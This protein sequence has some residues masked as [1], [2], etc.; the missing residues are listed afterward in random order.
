MSTTVY[1]RDQKVYFVC[2]GTSVNKI[3]QSLPE[4]T[5]KKTSF[6]TSLFKK[7]NDNNTEEIKEEK[8][9]I[10]DKIG[11]KE[12][13]I[14]QENEKNKE[15][16]DKVDTVYTSLD[17]NAI[18]TSLLL[19]DSSKNMTVVPLPYISKETNIKDNKKFNEFK[20]EFGKYSK[21]MNY[22]STNSTNYWKVK[23]IENDFI[24]KKKIAT[25]IDWNK[26]NT[27]DSSSL[28]SFNF[29][30]FKS[31]FQ[32]LILNKYISTSIYDPIDDLI[33]V[34][35]PSLIV[36]LL[37]MFKKVR[38]NA[39]KDVI[40]N[41]SIWEINLNI[42]FHIDNH[43]YFVKSKSKIIYDSYLKYYPTKYNHEP[44]K[45]LNNNYS[46]TYNDYK[47]IL[48]N[49]LQKIPLK[50]IKT[51]NLDYIN[52]NKRN[53]IKKIVNKNENKNKVKTNN[54]NKNTRNSTKLTIESLS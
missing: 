23:K 14:C 45:L 26:I 42:E 6:F 41:T 46:Y 40:E 44:L 49:S 31:E 21:I 3:I 54:S 48:F 37:K 47:Y 27:K 34:C 30:K 29:Q 52:T 5:N 2:Y 25:T 39:K 18:E 15:L 35:N 38:F 16:F 43:G 11:I 13:Y 20:L 19:F 33:F 51:L 10:L 22:E 50:Y 53:L 12:A 1:L 4:T 7:K 17:F 32:N 9:P 36:E 28:S 24:D 8:F